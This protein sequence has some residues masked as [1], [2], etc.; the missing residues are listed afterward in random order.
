M[1]AAATACR[2]WE[3]GGDADPVSDTAWGADEATTE[4]LEALAGIDPALA[5]DTYP[6]TRLGRLAL[7]ARLLVLAGTDEDG[8]STDLTAAA[9]ILASCVGE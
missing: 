9:G 4:A 7:A 5:L 3:D 8:R 1:T 2:G 6:E